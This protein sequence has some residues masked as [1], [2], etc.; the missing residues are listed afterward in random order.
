L[1]ALGAEY[2]VAVPSYLAVGP[3]FTAGFGG[4][5]V[6]ALGAG[7]RVYFIPN[8]S[9]VL[10]PY[11]TAGGGYGHVFVE[12]E[13]WNGG[14]VRF[15]GGTDFDIPNAPVAPFFDMGAF[16][17]IAG[18]GTGTAFLIEGGVRFDL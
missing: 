17:L 14:Y 4:G 13:D 16:M 12:D 9:Y 15:G 2:D 3:E 11:F 8:Y 7:S 6:V 5:T 18:D 1:A 10:Q